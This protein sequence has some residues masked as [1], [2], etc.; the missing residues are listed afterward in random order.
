MGRRIWWINLALAGC[1]VFLGVQTFQAWNRK[2][3]AVFSPGEPEVREANPLLDARIPPRR[4]LQPE[5]LYGAVTQ[6][7]LLSPDRA[8]Y[9]P[10]APEP[11]PEKAP[12]EI[13]VADAE[14]AVIS[15]RRISLR[16]V[17]LA[18]NFK[19]A[20]IDNPAP[21]QGDSGRIWVSEGEAL[22]G[23]T[24]QSVEREN[25]LLE[26]QGKI[27]RVSLYENEGTGASGRQSLAASAGKDQPRV[28]NTRIAPSVPEASGDASGND[29]LDRSRQKVLTPFD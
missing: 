3:P 9:V 1:A 7:N 19:K 15:G 14:P 5:S 6:R 20:L 23:V 18:G 26:H 8:E 10:P 4:P 29:T 27:Y 28:I 17:V 21:Q 24:V 11:E 13:A 12:K 25:V 22:D 16:G 2:I